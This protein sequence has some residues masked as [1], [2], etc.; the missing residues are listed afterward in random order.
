MYPLLQGEEK[1]ER[2]SRCYEYERVHKQRLVSFVLPAGKRQLNVPPY[3]AGARVLLCRHGI[4]RI[5]NVAW[6]QAAAAIEA[7]R[8]QAE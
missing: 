3:P 1:P 2:S 7:I 5:Q 6:E 4:V 8:W